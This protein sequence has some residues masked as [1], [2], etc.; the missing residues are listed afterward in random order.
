MLQERKVLRIAAQSGPTRYVDCSPLPHFHKESFDDCLVAAKAHFSGE[1]VKLPVSLSTAV[2]ALAFDFASPRAGAWENSGL[3]GLDSPIDSLMRVCKIKTAHHSLNELKKFLDLVMKR[4]PL[5]EFRIDCN[6]LLKSVDLY[7]LKSLVDDYPIQYIE[8]PSSSIADLKSLAKIIPIA[9]DENL[10]RDK[11]LDALA[12]AWV[13]KP[14]GLGWSKT[15][16][17]FSDR[18][19]ILKVLSNT[20]ESNAS[21]QL[22]AYLYAQ[23]VNQAQALGF[24]TAFYF[25]ESNLEWNA[26]VQKGFWPALPFAQ[27]DFEGT[28]LWEN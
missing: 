23:T 22:Y 6:Q 8:E 12:K 18:S 26:R 21:L 5:T 27:D 11:E 17:R 1:S 13:I 7:G 24:G 9:L 20:Y 10:G 4:N 14:N 25:E 28:Q 2:D 15:V 16:E 3:L 19:E